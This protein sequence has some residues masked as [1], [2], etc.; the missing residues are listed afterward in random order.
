MKA[1]IPFEYA[2]IGDDLSQA[3]SGRFN[4]EPHGH[5]SAIKLFFGAGDQESQVFLNLNDR[6]RKGQFSMKDP[7]YGDMV[8]A[9]LAN[10]L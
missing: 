5:W 8:L 4:T 9:A 1:S 10:V 2:D 3:R 7:D 6:I